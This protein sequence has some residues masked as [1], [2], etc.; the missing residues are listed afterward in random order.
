M[1]KHTNLEH[2]SRCS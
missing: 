1:K 2:C